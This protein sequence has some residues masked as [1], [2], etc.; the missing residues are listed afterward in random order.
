MDIKIPDL[1]KLHWQLNVAIIA[2]IFSIFSLIY[3]THYI[4]YGFLTFAFG[5]VGASILPAIENL[6]PND[7]WRNYLIVQTLLTIFWLTA[8]LWVYLK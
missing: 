6:Y 2:A 1:T 3:N 7:K 4:Y 5:V 8:C